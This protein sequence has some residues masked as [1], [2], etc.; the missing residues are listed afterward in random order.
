[1]RPMLAS[2]WEDRNEEMFPFWAQPKYDGI[3]VLIGHDGYA[4]SRSLKPIRNHEFQSWVRNYRDVFAGLDGEII[5]G[6]P[7]AKDCYTRTSSAVMSFNN[8]DISNAKLWI[9]DI[10][11]RGNDETYDERY[12]EL[13]DRASLF[14]H[15][16]EVAPTTLLIDMPMLLEYEER[17][18]SEGHEGIILRQKNSFYK[19]GRGTPKKGQLI[20]RKKFEDMEGEIIAVHELRHNANPATINALGYTEHSGHQEN[21]IP[22]DTLGAIEVRLGPE[23]NADSVRI[24][25]GLSDHT[26]KALWEDRENLIGRIAK[27]KYFAVGTKDAPRFPVFLGL[28]D[29]DDMSDDSQGSLF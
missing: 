11:D 22:M 3:R 13:L 6:D 5:V 17:R 24:G 25:T 19:Q 18:L 29:K 26:R 23:W 9:F 8:S 15:W 16:A 14:P 12:D 27:F 4:Y 28:R 1:M 20:K 21:L 10:W 7:T 2:K